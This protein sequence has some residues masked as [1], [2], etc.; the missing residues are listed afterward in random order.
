M[1]E[2]ERR[3]WEETAQD[4]WFNFRIAAQVVP[5]SWKRKADYGKRKEDYGKR[6]TSKR[7]KICGSQFW[8]RSPNLEPF[9]G[10]GLGEE[11]RR[12]REEENQQT[13]QD[14]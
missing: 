1:W 14:L 6:K 4:L 13:A 2:E 3:L 5:D 10:A 11:E 8:D 7:R 9:A 12:L